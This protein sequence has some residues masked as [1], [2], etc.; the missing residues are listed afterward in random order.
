MQTYNMMQAQYNYDRQQEYRTRG[1]NLLVSPIH[2][3]LRET[4]IK[5]MP[6]KYLNTVLKMQ[7]FDKNQIKTIKQQ[8]RR[9]KIKDYA[10]IN[11]IRTVLSDRKINHELRHLTELKQELI[12]RK[13]TLEE[14]I[15]KYKHFLSLN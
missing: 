11:K 9:M 15:T 7:N 10:E 1:E 5:D 13:E 3:Q 8:R 2:L 12:N 14:E 6:I 4:H